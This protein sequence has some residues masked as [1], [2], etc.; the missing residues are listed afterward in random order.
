ME[1]NLTL[2]QS[3]FYT[4]QN[5]YV[6][7]VAGFGSGK[8]EVA[9]TRMLSNMMESPGL[10][11]AYLA[12][13][14]PLIRDIWYPKVEDFMERLGLPY[15]INKSE[16][17]IRIQGL[18]KIFCRT[19][20]KPESII[21]WEVADAFLDE[22]DVLRTDK[23]LHVFRK[24]SARLRQKNPLGRKNQL[25]VTTTPEGFKA[26]HQLFK[27]EKLP[28]SALIQMSTYSNAANLP[29]DYIQN[30]RDQYPEQLIEAYLMGE[31]VNLQAGSVYYAYDRETLE[32]RYTARPQEAL[33]IGMDF[34]VNDMC[35]VVHIKR[36][37]ILYAVDELFGLRD[38][39]DMVDT[40]N[41]S[42]PDHHI[43][44]YPDASGRGTTS[45]SAS[46]SDIKILKA[47]GF[48]VK[49]KTKNPFIKDRVSSMNKCFEE[50]MYY[51]NTRR[52]PVYA[53]S[54][55]QQPYNITTGQPLKDG[56]YDNRVDGSGYMVN[57]LY[58]VV[59]PN[60]R[61]RSIGGF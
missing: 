30:L 19:M 61:Q 37:G 28:D 29:E 49:A 9:L 12:P 17:V 2:P 14:Y 20:E 60:L 55:E 27:K 21:G 48:S 25:F 1:I 53:D 6:A 39:P 3:E 22:F 18:G 33:H 52:C 24:I 45:K 43:T 5:K 54:L 23:A 10:H 15:Q 4:S 40:L 57:Y 59:K 35:A 38:T 11:Q 26:T 16:H 36:K 34:N 32:T 51:V 13:T 47:G 58:P 44:I 50:R 7:A 42:Y 56:N 46:T 8:T 41:E 31:F